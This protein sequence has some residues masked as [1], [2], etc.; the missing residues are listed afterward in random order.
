MVQLSR[1]EL[2][3]G[4]VIRGICQLD[5]FINCGLVHQAD[6]F[7]D[8]GAP[9][10]YQR[11]RAFKRRLECCEKPLCTIRRGRRGLR[12]S[13]LAL[14]G[15]EAELPFVTQLARSIE[16][17]IRE[18]VGELLLNVCRAVAQQKYFET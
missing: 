4:I 6:A 15:P 3:D 12:L 16:G 1:V 5:H 18:G 11:R 2:S 9:L 8:N 13:L 14:L 17:D 7:R 10:L